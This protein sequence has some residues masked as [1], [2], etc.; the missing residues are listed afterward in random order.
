VF[1]ELVSKLI[2]EVSVVTGIVVVL[3]VVIVVEDESVV[4]V[5]SPSLLQAT[6]VI[7][8]IAAIVKNFF[9]F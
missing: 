2:L 4:S 5:L 6:K 8:A 9:I 1:I 7:A 3:S